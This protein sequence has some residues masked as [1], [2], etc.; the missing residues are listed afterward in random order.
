MDLTYARRMCS[1]RG[2]LEIEA[3]KLKAETH[4]P[5]DPFFLPLSENQGLNRHL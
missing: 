3:E 2:R 4:A 5:I 1:F